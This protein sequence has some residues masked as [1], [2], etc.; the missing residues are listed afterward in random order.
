MGPSDFHF[1]VS[2]MKHLDDK[3]FA[4]DANVKQAVPPVY[5]TPYTDFSYTE[6]QA[7]VSW[8]TNA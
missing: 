4:T 2:L 8:W 5:K 1:I 7:L 6:I 3:K